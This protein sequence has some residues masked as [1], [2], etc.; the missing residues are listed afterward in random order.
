M[1]GKRITVNFDNAATT[2]PLHGVMERIFHFSEVYASVHRGAGYKS[3][4]SS[5][6]Y[7]RGRAQLMRFV[8]A[9]AEKYMLIYTKHTTEALNL[10]AHMMRER[11]DIEQ[12]IILISEMEHLANYLPWRVSGQV[13]IV[14]VD[15]AGR[16]RLDILEEMLKRYGG[17][18]KLVCVSGASNVT[19]YVNSLGKI[20]RIVHRYRAMLVVDGAQLAP[21]MRVDMA[22]QS[23]EDAIDFFA[24]SAHKMYAPFGCGALIGRKEILAEA[25]PMLVGGGVARL[26]THTSIDWNDAPYRDEAG[27]PNVIGVTAWTEAIQILMECGWEEMAHREMCLMRLLLQGLRRID[28]I[29]LYGGAADGVSLVSF[30]LDGVDHRMVSRI[31]SYEDGIA[32]RSGMFCAHPYVTRLL[33]TDSEQL[34]YAKQHR[35]ASL[36]GMVRVSLSFYNTEEEVER[37]LKLMRR[38]SKHR[39]EYVKKY[40]QMTDYWMKENKRQLS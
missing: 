6:V 8:N 19:G 38:I 35:D 11:L 2:P 13:D 21:H 22:G 24:F 39:R 14:P 33:G 34:A 7:E 29:R 9:D 36:P 31:L 28:G 30:T 3:M 18:V 4:I 17:H 32:V 20:A 37:F 1:N 25:H 10:L 23:A 27:T 5:D 12:D 16:L 26:V 15:E 40:Q